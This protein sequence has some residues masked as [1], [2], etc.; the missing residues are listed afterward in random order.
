MA[1]PHTN[2]SA[3]RARNLLRLIHQEKELQRK[4]RFPMSPMVVL[5]EGCH[6]STGQTVVH[7]LVAAGLLHE[8]RRFCALYPRDVP[9]TKT[10]R[11]GET[12]YEAAALDGRKEICKF[13]DRCVA[14]RGMPSDAMMETVARERFFESSP[15]PSTTCLDTRDLRTELLRWE[16]RLEKA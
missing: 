12:P 9:Y 10:N 4:S 14:L 13:L 15:P 8:L 1:T 6:P 3:V 11:E 16:K 7:L 5:L 2:L